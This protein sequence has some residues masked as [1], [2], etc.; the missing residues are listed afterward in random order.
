M[1]YRQSESF[2]RTAQAFAEV[3][4][5]EEDEGR[6]LDELLT[7]RDNLPEPSQAAQAGLFV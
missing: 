3:L 4:G 5:D 2:W 6:A 1:K 7:L